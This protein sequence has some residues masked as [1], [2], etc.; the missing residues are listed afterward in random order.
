MTNGSGKGMNGH[1][2]ADKDDMV[3]ITINY[4]LGAL[5]FLDMSDIGKKYAQ[6]GNLGLLDVIAALKWVHENIAAFGGD[7]ND[8]AFPSP[9]F[10]LR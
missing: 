4:R 3:T 7:H 8:P 10:I 2:F 6:S 9:V 1:A 5:G